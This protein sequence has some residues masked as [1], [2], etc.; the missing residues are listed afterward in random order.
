[1]TKAKIKSTP[2]R[3]YSHSFRCTNSTT[4]NFAMVQPVLCR[5]MQPSSTIK[6]HMNQFV[7]LAP[8]PW[9]TFG[10]IRVRQESVFIPIEDVFPQFAPFMGEKEVDGSYLSYT[11]DTANNVK[12]TSVS[13]TGIPRVLPQTSNRQLAL[14][15]Y[16]SAYADTTVYKLKNGG[17][18]VP[19]DSPVLLSAS[20]MYDTLYTQYSSGKPM[21]LST[22]DK[23]GNVVEKEYHNVNTERVFK[24]ISENK[25]SREAAV[26]AISNEVLPADFVNF[27]DNQASFDYI[28]FT[29]PDR[30]SDKGYIT[31]YKLNNLGRQL[32]KVLLG[33]GYN[34]SYDDNTRVSVL[35]LVAFAKAYYDRFI[36]FREKPYTATVI[37]KFVEA[38]QSDPLLYELRNNKTAPFPDSSVGSVE[39]NIIC[40]VPVDNLT[41]DYKTLNQMFCQMIHLY[42]SRAY[43]TQETNFISAHVSTLLNGQSLSYPTDVYPWIGDSANDGS[44]GGSFSS[45]TQGSISSKGSPIPGQP[46]LATGD[47]S[48]TGG[49]AR[50]NYINA[51]QIKLAQKLY[52]MMNR[53]SL[54]GNRLDLYLR[55]HFDSAIYN[56]LFKRS[57]VQT[58]SDFRVSIGDVDSTADTSDLA[59]DNKGVVLGA[60]SGKGIG[61]GGLQLDY[62]SKTYGWYIVY[63]WI[64]PVTDYYQGTDTQLF[65]SDKYS[66]PQAEYDALGYEITPQSAVWTDNGISV[67]NTYTYGRFGPNSQHR[68]DNYVLDNNHGFGFIPRYSGF[69]RAKNI[70]NGDMSIR[71]R[72]SDMNAFYIDREFDCRH[73]EHVRDGN[74]DYVHVTINDLPVASAEWKFT[75]RYPYMGNYDRIFYNSGNKTTYRPYEDTSNLSDNFFVHLVFDWTENTPLKPLS[76][77]YDTSIMKGESEV[78]V[79]QA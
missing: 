70:V 42:V 75:K 66:V 55:N 56:E 9:P 28:D 24:N 50:P 59:R 54:I 44:V 62:T 2:S 1:M 13:Y 67:I 37:Y 46:A 21:M 52:G 18:T 10:D 27:F 16:S 49:S 6:G 71:S 41:N 36:P 34:P 65:L 23:D 26:Q 11:Y 3:K 79:T 61:T 58:S 76:L 7:R 72:Q 64:D 30:L 68:N 14:L 4:A 74:T 8:L 22:T 35:P 29:S 48:L 38:L 60:Y 63:M 20:E 39:N 19:G 33:L 40:Y 15:L 12:T 25:L 47:V 45:I 51:I 5:F 43:S 53:N 78:A 57:S 73:F 17:S 32:R 69:K 77:S 31:C